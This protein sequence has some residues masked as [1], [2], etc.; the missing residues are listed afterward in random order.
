MR[1]G[2]RKK[3]DLLK[4]IVTCRRENTTLKAWRDEYK[5]SE[6]ALRESEKKYQQLLNTLHEG[7]WVIDQDANTTFVNPRM[8][9]MLG[10][11]VEDMLGK[12]LFSFMDEQRV[13]VAQQNLERRRRGILEQHDF[14]FLR[15]DG[16]RI[17]ASLATSPITDQDGNYV[18]A[19]AWVQDISVRRQA[20][21]A[22]RQAR[23]DLESCVEQRTLELLKTNEL[24]KSEILERKG[25]EEALRLSETKYRI[26]SDNTYDWE[27]WFSPEGDF[28]YVS[29][30]CERVTGR[31]PH[32]FLSDVQLLHR[33]IHPEDRPTFEDHHRDVESRFVSGEVE[34]RIIPRDG[35]VRWLAHACQPVFDSAGQYLGRRGSNRDITERK[36]AEEALKESERQLRFLSSELI[37]AQEKERRRIAQELHDGIGQILAATKFALETKLNQRASNG[38]SP[39]PSLENLIALVQNGIEEARRIQSDLRPSMLDDLGILPT[40]NWFC[41]EFET[42][43]SNLRIDKQIDVVE[44]DVPDPLKIVLYRIMQEG[45]NNVSKYS[46][47]TRVFLS[48]QKKD[49]RIELLIRDN[50]VGFD[51]KEA[52]SNKKRQKGL[53]L[54]SMRERAELSGGSF[55][56]ESTEGKGTTIRVSWSIG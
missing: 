41:R 32:E 10:Y 39:G 54:A 20:E 40:I 14:E 9:E 34:F 24:L 44:Q 1:D 49:R 13:E 35:S 30:S 22:L 52:L 56:M 48:L 51:L 36:Q 38:A 17:Y 4:E 5:R 2:D 46:K 37:F 26:V 45:L 21:E 8:A 3:E 42:I 7:I 16:S 31:Q 15:K 18:G 29:P 12:H 43:Y 33:I 19:I 53:G 28:V 55:K 23:D 50:G 27:W 6:Q 11:T 47:A 25:T